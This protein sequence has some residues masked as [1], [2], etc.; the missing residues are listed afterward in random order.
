M[1]IEAIEGDGWGREVGLRE[2]G[3]GELEAVEGGFGH[4]VLFGPLAPVAA[5]VGVFLKAAIDSILD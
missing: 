1:G 2:L 4:L 5:T 3:Q